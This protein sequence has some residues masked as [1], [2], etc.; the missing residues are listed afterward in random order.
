MSRRII[1]PALVM[2]LGIAVTLPLSAHDEGTSTPQQKARD[3]HYHELGD[4]FKA[5]RDGSK[6]DKPDFAA[7]KKNAKI[8]NDGS[9]DQDQWF[10]KGS[11]PEAGK[12][13]ALP[14][15]WTKPEDFKAAQK[16]FADAA[17]K[18]LAAANASDIGAVRASFA[19]V[20]KTCK[21]CHQS[22]RKPEE[23]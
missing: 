20:G 19:D 9:I 16:A 2:C 15:I 1:T 5:I 17:P 13:A 11:G 23:H 21:G 8:V 3:H 12:T 6:T 10:P 7:L 18:L 14:E 4:A 22:F